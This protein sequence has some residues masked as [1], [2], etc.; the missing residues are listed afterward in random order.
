MDNRLKQK[1]SFDV[2]VVTVIGANGTMGRNVSA[3]FASFGNAKVYMISRSI[4]KSEKAK[5]KAYQTVR[6]ESVK[7][8]MYPKTFEDLEQ[9]IA[10]SDL[11]FES[12]AE[13]WEIKADVT[14]LI[15]DAAYKNIDKNINTVFCTGSSGQSITTLAEFFPESLRCNYFGF[16]MFNPPYVMTLAEMIPTKYTNRK[17]FEDVLL[18]A[19]A[20]L[21][22]TVVEVKD[23]P[24]FLGNRIGFQFINEVLQKA[25]ELKDSGGIDYVDAI[26][27]SFTGRNMSP[28]QTSNFVGLDV[29]KEIVSNLFE[30]TDDFA[31]DTFVLPAFAE[32]LIK[33]GQLGLKTGS[34]LYQTYVHDNGTK[35]RQVYDIDKKSYRNVIKYSFPFVEQIV[36]SLREGNYDD[37]FHVLKT[38]QSFE[39][40]FALY[41]VLKYIIYSLKATEMVGYDVHSADDVMAA[42]FNWCPPLAMIEALG[43]VDEVKRL[44]SDIFIDSTIDK[45]ELDHLLLTVEPSKYDYRK[46]I[47]AKH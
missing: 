2:S 13:N 17:L 15:A 10:E 45:S 46:Y 23:S 20:R 16:H 29:H 6:A 19:K 5:E 27:G 39:C 33:N 43:G 34:G 47:K 40:R 41:F 9:C 42:G 24:A 14:K 32:E 12:C 25:E 35:I 28:L 37:A 4:E 31:R 18:Y 1:N 21:F 26:I 44:S 8:N 30:N 3:I 38:N 36:S 22:R 7:D 11:V